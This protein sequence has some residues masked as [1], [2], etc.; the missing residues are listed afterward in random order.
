MIYAIFYFSLKTTIFKSGVDFTKE[1]K[2]KGR[3]GGEA[4]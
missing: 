3:G 4:K 1:K 2:K